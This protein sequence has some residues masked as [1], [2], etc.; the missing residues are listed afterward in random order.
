MIHLL[1]CY[2]I[3]AG[4]SIIV[5]NKLFVTDIMKAAGTAI[6][7]TCVQDLDFASE[8]DAIVDGA[9]QV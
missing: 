1:H 9:A 7:H 8:F 3:I 2:L 4:Q 5:Q 6:R